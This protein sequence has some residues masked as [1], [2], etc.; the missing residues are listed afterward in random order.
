MPNK[1]QCTDLRSIYLMGLRRSLQPG[2]L[3]DG[4]LH[5]EFQGR[6]A[7]LNT[8]ASCFRILVKHFHGIERVFIKVFPY[9]LKFF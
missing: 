9:Q 6:S 2:S 4:G 7:E 5:S 8:K 3:P 1:S